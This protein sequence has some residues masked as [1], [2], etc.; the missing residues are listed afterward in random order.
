[1]RYSKSSLYLIQ[2]AGYFYVSFFLLETSE[3]E[4]LDQVSDSIGFNYRT[5]TLFHPIKL[6]SQITTRQDIS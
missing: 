4:F 5:I 1:M 3:F 6:T 2:N